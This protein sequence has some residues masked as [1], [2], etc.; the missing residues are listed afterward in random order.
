M[1]AGNNQTTDWADFEELDSQ[2]PIK[3]ADPRD[4]V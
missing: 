3:K 2:I 4:L 1:N